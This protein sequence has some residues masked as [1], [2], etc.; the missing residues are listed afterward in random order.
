MIKQSKKKKK[1]V[2]QLPIP[3]PVADIINQSRQI[4]PRNLNAAQNS[5]QQYVL[6]ATI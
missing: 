3:Q 1:K 4:L 6:S 2:T 5:L